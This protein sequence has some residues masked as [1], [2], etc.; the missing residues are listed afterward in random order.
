MTETEAKE[1]A[2]PMLWQSS[3]IIAAA[4]DNREQ[5]TN[6]DGH[7]CVGSACMLWRATEPLR[8]FNG[9]PA[10]AGY[11]TAYPEA[12]QMVGQG[13]CGLGGKP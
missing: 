8:L 12:T 10:P 2:C 6:K 9:Q 13:Y 7:N 11:E 4:F 5:L 3:V 1:K